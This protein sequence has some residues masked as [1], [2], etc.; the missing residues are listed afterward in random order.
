[1]MKDRGLNSNLIGLLGRVERSKADDLLV[2]LYL[3]VETASAGF[4]IDAAVSCFAFCLAVVLLILSAGRFTQIG[5]AIIAWFAIPM[6]AF[7]VWPASDHVEEGQSVLK[8]ELAGYSD[9][10]VAIGSKRARS[11]AGPDWSIVHL[12]SPN[13]GLWI[14]FQ[15]VLKAL[16]I[17]DIFQIDVGGHETT[18]TNGV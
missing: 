11:I 12:P 10:P 1:M 14:V 16:L 18:A 4:K 17:H 3:G 6:F 9:L 13:S 2:D 8:V 5:P 15:K 7:W